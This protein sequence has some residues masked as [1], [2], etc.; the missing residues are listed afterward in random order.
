MTLRLRP[1]SDAD[2]LCSTSMF[3]YEANKT[4]DG[5]VWW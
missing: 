1:G 5:I 4:W 3:E 2:F